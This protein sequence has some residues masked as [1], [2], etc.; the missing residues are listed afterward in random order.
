MPCERCAR[1]GKTCGGYRDLGELLFRDQTALL[2]GR[3]GSPSR[4][5]TPSPRQL[6]PSKVEMATAF[7][8]DQ[9]VSDAQHG[10]MR[11]LN[12][13]GF[14]QKPVAACALAAIANRSKDMAGRKLAR[15][16]YVEALA[17]TNGALRDVR[18]AKEDNTLVS[19]LLLGW[20]EVSIG[21]LDQGCLLSPP[22]CQSTCEIE[23]RHCSVKSS[24]H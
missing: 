10:F 19:V 9:I 23:R 20:F 7:F 16:Y 21:A 8:F 11:D 4:Q 15:T 13:D 2:S 14:L 5:A 12:I 1:L 22:P 18:R 3:T 17:A 6:S 24:L